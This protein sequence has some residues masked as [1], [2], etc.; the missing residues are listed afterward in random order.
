MQPAGGTWPLVWS[1]AQVRQPFG[2][3]RPCNC[4]TLASAK[5]TLTANRGG[6]MT[7]SLLTVPIWFFFSKHKWTWMH[8][9]AAT[10]RCCPHDEKLRHKGNFLNVMTMI[11]RWG[12]NSVGG[13]GLQLMHNKQTLKETIEE[14]IENWSH[15]Y[16]S[17]S[18]HLSG[19]QYQNPSASPL[20]NKQ[21][22]LREWSSL[23]AW[24]AQCVSKETQQQLAKPN[25]GTWKLILETNSENDRF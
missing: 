4:Y 24:V 5:K 21:K 7:N 19:K 18:N 12:R 15:W 22:Y 14:T 2:F 25:Q 17:H 8:H 10:E 9:I 3:T 6:V 1:W 23:E 20:F 16:P 11:S 13:L